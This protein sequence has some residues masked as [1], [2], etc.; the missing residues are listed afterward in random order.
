[1]NTYNNLN[2]LADAVH[3]N[4]VEKGFHNYGESNIH[5]MANQCNNIHAEVTELWDAFR[6]GTEWE[7][8]DKPIQLTQLE[9]EL[10]D[11]IIRAL[12]VS[13][14]LGVDIVNAIHVKHEYNKT[15]PYMHGKKN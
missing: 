1:M 9:E 6:A 11:I 10:A 12:D 5:F 7:A 8:C 4:A 14:R 15:R 2:D 13:R 3:L